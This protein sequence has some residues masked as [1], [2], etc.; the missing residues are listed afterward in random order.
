MTS[1]QIKFIRNNFYNRAADKF[2]SAK[3]FLR[4]TAFM[5]CVL[6]FSVAVNAATFTVTNVND[7]GAGSLRA[8]ITSANA[9]PMTAHT[10]NFN[11]G[12]GLKT[13]TVSS[14]LPTISL[15]NLTIDGTM[16]SGFA[17]VPLIQLSGNNAGGSAN[18]LKIGKG[19]VTIKS[20]I[21]NQFAGS[22]I[23]ASGSDVSLN[24]YGCYIGTDANGSADLG[25]SLSGVYLNPG[26]DNVISNIGGT[27][28]N[29]RNVISGNNGAGVYISGFYSAD[30]KIINNY[31][32]TNASAVIDLGNSGDGIVIAD[33]QDNV[34]KVIVGGSQT[35][36]RNIISGNNKNGIYI[37]LSQ[38]V[39]ISGNY[40]GLGA[41]GLTTIGNT[42][43]GI[44]FS[45]EGTVVENVIIGGTNGAGNTISANGSDGIEV[46]YYDFL[47]LGTVS[48]LIIGNRIGTDHSGTND[49]GNVQ[50]G[51]LVTGLATPAIGRENA[52]E[53]NTISGNGGAGIYF[54]GGSGTVYNNRVGVSS[55]GAALPNGGAGV[56]M[57]GIYGVQIGK[58]NVAAAA[59]VIGSNGAH[60]IYVG[61]NSSNFKILNNFIGTTAT[62]GSI[63][64]IGSGIFV[65]DTA[66]H[67]TIGSANAG[68][69]NTIA[70][71]TSSGVSIAPNAGNSAPSA[72]AVLRNSIYSNGALGIDLGGDGVTFNDAGDVDTGANGLQNFPVIQGA[73]TAQVNGTLQSTPN[74][75]F[76]LDFYRVDS[77]HSANGYGAGRYHVGTIDATTDAGGNVQFLASNMTLATGQIITATATQKNQA[78]FESTSEFSQC[79]TVSQPPGN[80]SLS[81]ATYAVNESAGTATVTVNR[82]NGNSGTISVAYAASNG[83]ATAGKDYTATSGTLTFLNGETSKTFSIPV[84]DDNSDEPAETVNITLSNPVGGAAIVNPQTAILTVNDNDDAPIVSV[85]DVAMLE[86]NEGAKQFTFNV[87][88]SAASGF[89]VAV[90]YQTANGTATASVDYQSA[91]GTINFAAGEISKLVTVAVNG[92]TLVEINETF[93]LNLSNPSN[94]TVHNAGTAT[95]QDDDNPGKLQ[96]S[97]ANFSIAENGGSATITVTRTGGAAGAVSVDYAT[98]NGTAIAGQDYA[99]TSGNLVLNDGQQSATFAVAISNDAT[100][101]ADETVFLALSNPLGGA[102]LGAANATLTIQDDDQSPA[103]YALS[104]TVTYANSPVNQTV[105]SVPGVKLDAVGASTLSATSNESG[106]YQIT[107]INAGGNYI[108][109]AS[110]TL[111]TDVNGINSLDATRIQQHLVG[112]TTL[113]PNQLLA[114]DTDGNGTVNSL[115]ATRIQ[116]H[117]VGIKST[118]VIGQWKFVPASKSYNT[119]NSDL[120]DEN[121]QAVLIGE[122][123]GNWIAPGQSAADSLNTEKE[124]LAEQQNP[125]AAER[126]NEIAEQIESSDIEI[127]APISPKT[128]ESA[129]LKPNVSR[130][131]SAVAEATV[132][133]SLPVNATASPG[134]IVTIPVAV[135]ALPPGMPIES[136][137]FSVFFDPTVLQPTAPSAGSNAGT[138]SAQCS[139]FA[140]SPLS[141]KVIVSG[142]CSNPPITQGAGVLYNLTF[143]VVGAGNQQTQLSFT[144]PQTNIVK[145]QFN[146][147][148]PE[149]TTI[150]GQFTG[151]GP[152]A[153][154]VSVVGR[155]T[156]AQGRGIG[157][158]MIT[159]IDS[160]G[161]ERTTRTNNFGY[162]RFDAVAARETVTISVKARRYRFGQSSIVRT[163][164][165]SISDA[166]FVSEY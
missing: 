109:S 124:S 94:A 32:G 17:N 98:Q 67:G 26:N 37:G 149:V 84:N 106:F 134:E 151:L 46:G 78:F 3:S 129:S 153:A 76:R 82:T 57:I 166:D 28:A 118:N 63:G 138:L 43:D 161:G 147:G 93:L 143:A 51:I 95:I 121:Y 140:N 154:T 150:G 119:V 135:G 123:S 29:Q 130:S 72:I 112:L 66:T 14:P 86:G 139:A 127:G 96:F 77:C 56:R 85:S 132:A 65:T 115:D 90:N 9:A 36:Q 47:G 50:N 117:L 128:E 141:G 80:F 42:E 142:A 125:D 15:T 89:P 20:L 24:V 18:G 101:E 19:E 126:D 120:T 13:I 110:K 136:F 148:T 162:Y 61:G 164:N 12:S 102:T 116:Q 10:I 131:D 23:Y 137:D 1:E 49:R 107:G 34:S 160:N 108:V 44:N 114:A 157:N 92:D 39:T 81:A 60:G 74:K 11:I 155:V 99:A 7:S 159:M 27:A 104:G 87:T 2:I 48:P 52:G 62:N 53:G 21:I 158:A 58:E 146:N 165:E 68:G 6:F 45:P 144:D 70:N 105:Q 145:F 22:G 33:Y 100:G 75:T 54:S 71:N 59:N 31:I 152:T 113:T 5:L 25:N 163:T 8:A 30:V 55:L 4:A 103:S 35:E 91:N 133:V 16:Q 156:A 97:A 69:G 111:Q 79:F 122:V 64:N 41:N 88:L 83:T 73:S 38:S 40:I